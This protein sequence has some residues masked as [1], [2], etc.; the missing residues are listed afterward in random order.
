MPCQD[1]SDDR[2]VID[3]IHHRLDTVTDMLCN[4]CDKVEKR[5]MID[6]LTNETRNWWIAHK[7][8]DAQRAKFLKKERKEIEDRDAALGKLS[9]RERKLL[10]V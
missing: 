2:E 1:Y 6:L 4:L 9:K 5:E 8:S 7:R 3:G 10:G